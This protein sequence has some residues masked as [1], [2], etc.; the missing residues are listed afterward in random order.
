MAFSTGEDVMRKVEKL[1]KSLYKNFAR[2]GTNLEA[3]LPDSR[4]N[5]ITYVKAMSKY[6]SDKPD[7]RLKGLVSYN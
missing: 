5:R 6:G 7:L 2:P 3:P 4:F 1:S